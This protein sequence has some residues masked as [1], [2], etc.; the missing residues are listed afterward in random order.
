M[1]ANGVPPGSDVSALPTRER[2]LR[3]SSELRMESPIMRS[4]RRALVVT[5]AVV[6]LAGC[7]S[8]G[9]DDSDSTGGAGGT[10]G[11]AAGAGASEDPA[12]S[13]EAFLDAMAAG[14]TAVMCAV[15]GTV[16]EV[17]TGPVDA[18]HWPQSECEAEMSAD[19]EGI[20]DEALADVEVEGEPEMV[21]Q[22][23]G[24]E[25][26]FDRDRLAGLDDTTLAESNYGLKLMQ[27]GGLWYVTIAF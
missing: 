17:Y 21:E 23:H 5:A 26:R 18:T 25:A 1:P 13:A 24:T 4:I 15:S 12:A 22:T 20:G 27:F 16:S 19:V 11:E 2:V 8:V 9:E 7:G 10:G 14:D 6:L 3:P